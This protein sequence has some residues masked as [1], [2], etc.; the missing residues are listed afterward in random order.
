MSTGYV[1]DDLT[2]HELGRGDFT[3]VN[4]VAALDSHA[5]RISVPALALADAHRGLHAD[6]IDAIHGMIHR[7]RQVRLEPLTTTEDVL[8]LSAVS[9]Y[10]TERLDLAAAHTVATARHLDE[11]ILTVNLKRWE[12]IQDLLPWTLDVVEI[13]E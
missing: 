6:Q 1:L 10:L 13:T 5:V 9:A 3:V 2:L 8:R 12:P 4:V 7:L 11:P